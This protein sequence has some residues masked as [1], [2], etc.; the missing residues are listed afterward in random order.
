MDDWAH[1]VL[2]R[3]RAAFTLIE[4]LLVIAIMGVLT[5]VILPQFSVGMSGSRVRTAFSTS[6]ANSFVLA[7]GRSARAAITA[8]AIA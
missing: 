2:K 5:A 6:A 8:V 4:L 1:N 7:I 3:G